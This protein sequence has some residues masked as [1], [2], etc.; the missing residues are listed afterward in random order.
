VE[1]VM[2]K[3]SVIGLGAMGSAIAACLMKKGHAITV[4]NRSPGK[5]EPL[6]AL[7]A[8]AA[9]TVADAV[10]ASP[11]VIT[12]VKSHI[13]TRALLEPHARALAGKTLCECSSGD[14][15]DAEKLV[16]ILK[17]QG[18]DYLVGMINAYPSGIGKD[19]TTIL[20]VGT[21]AAWARHGTIIKTLG[22]RSANIGT[23]PAAL[24]ALFAG[25]FTV[26]QGCM[27]GMIY[28]ALV[29]QKAGVSLKDFAE[30]IPVSFKLMDDYYKVFAATVPD[31]NYDNPE[32]AMATYADS[33]EDALRTFKARG[34]RCE[35][36]QLMSDTVKAAVAAGFGNKQLTALVSYLSR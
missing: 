22:G 8:T 30:Q 17:N 19:D 33:L 18:A 21:P 5:M 24:A 4:W 27:F 15:G 1:A 13:E 26:R 34:A 10:A 16:A 2:E 20:T 14:A 11:L 25:H 36:P 7:G 35:L 3:I 12:C 23:E 32:A 31:G 28:G 9:R 29:C 6:V